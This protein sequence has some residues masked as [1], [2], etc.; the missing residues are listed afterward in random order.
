MVDMNIE[1][2][3]SIIEFD[4]QYGKREKISIHIDYLGFIT[5]K[6][7]KHTSEELIVSNIKL[8]GKWILD[9]LKEINMAREVTKQGEYYNKGKLLYLGKEYFPHELI[10]VRELDEVGI[11]KNIKKFY[12]DGCRKII[13]ERIKIY[14][15]QLG[16]KP[17]TIEIVESRT[18]WGSC[19]SDRKISFNYN[20]VM[21]PIDVIDYVVVHELCHLIHMNH[22]R[23][24]WRRV[25][26]IIPDYK[27]KQEYLARMKIII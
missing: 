8:Q 6:A 15:P 20:L 17:K 22:D 16:V 7:P 26:S 14:Q 10:E 27:S 13:G 21:A 1:I 23:S 12:I 18:N 25:G 4:I 3:N 9:K 2:E 11:K 24:F 5:V 19:S